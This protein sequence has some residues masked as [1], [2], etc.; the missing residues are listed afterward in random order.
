MNSKKTFLLVII[1]ILFLA[2]SS[3][4]D[5]CWKI[6]GTEYCSEV[7]GGHCHHI[8]GDY[9]TLYAMGFSDSNVNVT[10]GGVDYNRAIPVG[11]QISIS[12]INKYVTK[13]VDGQE[14]SARSVVKLFVDGEAV[15]NNGL[16][17][18]GG[19][20]CGGGSLI[21]GTSKDFNYT[22]I[23]AGPHLVEI[24]VNADIQGNRWH[25]LDSFNMI[26]INIDYNVASQQSL[27]GFMRGIDEIRNEA[28]KDVVWSV[29]NLTDNTLVIKEAQITSCPITNCEIDSG[30]FPFN[31]EPH[32]EAMFLITLTAQ[33][34][35]VSPE[36]TP[37][38]VKLRVGDLYGFFDQDGIVTQDP[39]NV[40][41]EFDAVQSAYAPYV[42]TGTLSLGTGTYYTQL[43]SDSVTNDTEPVLI[44]LIVFDDTDSDGF[45]TDTVDNMIVNASFHEVADCSGPLFLPSHDNGLLLPPTCFVDIVGEPAT[46]SFSLSSART[47]N[48]QYSGIVGTGTNYTSDWARIGTGVSSSNCY[49]TGYSSLLDTSFG[50]QTKHFS[51]SEHG[52]GIVTFEEG[53]KVLGTYT[54]SLNVPEMGLVNYELTNI[55]MT[56]PVD[57]GYSNASYLGP[58]SSISD[59]TTVIS[60]SSDSG[61]VVASTTAYKEVAGASNFVDD[62]V[63]LWEW[64]ER[65]MVKV[66]AGLEDACYGKNGRVGFSG[67][68]VAPKLNY[69]WNWSAEEE[70]I[71]INACQ[72]N[73]PDYIYCDATQ[74]T[75]MLLQRLHRLQEI[76]DT[77]D[78][79]SDYVDEIDELVHF[80]AY[81]MYDSFND[82]FREDFVSYMATEYLTPTWYAQEMWDDYLDPANNALRFNAD[83]TKVPDLSGP[84]LYT[85]NLGFEFPAGTMYSFNDGS[86]IIA[87]ITVDMNLMRGPTYDNPFYYLPIDAMLGYNDV[88]EKLEREGYGTAFTG[89][90]SRNIVIYGQDDDRFTPTESDVTS[91]NPLVKLDI[92]ELSDS[93]HFEFVQF[94]NPGTVLEISKTE[95]VPLEYTLQYTPAYATLVA[96]K[97]E[98][99]DAQA[100]AA[101]AFYKLTDKDLIN[102]SSYEHLNSWTCLAETIEEF[103]CR[104]YMG[105]ALFYEKA[106]LKADGSGMGGFTDDAGYA[107][108][109]AWNTD[110]NGAIYTGTTFFTPWYYSDT[111]ANAEVYTLTNTGHQGILYKA[112]AGEVIDISRG[113]I[114]YMDG[115][116]EVTN[117]INNNLRS[118]KE[119]KL[120]MVWNR[121]NRVSLFWNYDMLLDELINT[122]PES[123]ELRENYCDVEMTLSD[124][125]IDTVERAPWCGDEACNGE[126][127][128]NS[129]ERDCG[130]CCGDGECTAEYGED[131]TSCA[132][133]CGL[134]CGDG[135]CTL[136]YGEDCDSCET[137]CD[138][139]CG[140]GVCSAEYEED[141]TSCAADCDPPPEE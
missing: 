124:E 9:D 43:C 114:F 32:N 51:A 127:S 137:D 26:V 83:D 56:Y 81:L 105:E 17:T 35:D 107:Y 19:G 140:D 47:V 82:S 50:V 125:Y 20:A 118:V 33:S 77:A 67:E 80:E 97:T 12:N 90:I 55:Q 116:P 34:P 24:K 42:R 58:D 135:I 94:D 89:D 25:T 31:V 111:T 128:C 27:L 60:V 104:G 115:H 64:R 22:F 99:E 49:V 63:L 6:G 138:P 96:M 95:E 53:N 61:E 48:W 119:G 121:D 106:D 109:F 85:I 30:L 15:A 37:V 40:G 110:L 93:E 2:V 36:L 10:E 39:V 44:N 100:N 21:Y 28:T 68:D 57:S 129:C 46:M 123:S 126:E 3:Y 112:L 13:C 92:S 101:G 73:N 87:N 76:A 79:L 120:C 71:A 23:G 84:G 59:G 75:I 54:P 108:G 5:V 131:C 65:Y 98:K 141:Y 86:A 117:S 132:A 91:F 14:G 62:A 122:F 41:L 8:K 78:N 4:A 134:C 74:F 7:T 16:K 11:G 102:V 66:F 139:C 88:T 18:G 29:T 69:H 72:A 1:S 136:E 38:G 113:E 70:V 52:T 130:V 103:D 133:D 45:Y